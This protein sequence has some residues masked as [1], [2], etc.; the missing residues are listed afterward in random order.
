MPYKNEEQRKEANRLSM[1]RK[2][3]GYTTGV[4][5]DGVHKDN[6]TPLLHRPN[7]LGANELPEMVDNMYDPTERLYDSPHYEPGTLRYVPCHDG[8]VLDRLSVGLHN[9]R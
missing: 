5:T 6:V 3:K 8:R 4:H 7:R 9:E 2:R 1:E